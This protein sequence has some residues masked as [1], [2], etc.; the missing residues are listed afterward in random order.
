[1]G[2]PFMHEFKKDLRPLSEEEK[3]LRKRIDNNMENVTPEEYDAFVLGR[4]RSKVAE[5]AK[6]KLESLLEKEKEYNGLELGSGTGIYTK[7][8]NLIPNLK[9]TGIDIRKDMID[10]GAKNGRFLDG[11]V[12]QGDFNRMNFDDNSFELGTGLAFTR[13]RLNKSIFYNELKRVLKNG[14][15]FFVPFTKPKEDTIENEIELM[16]QNGF[17]IIEKSDWYIVAKNS[18][19]IIEKNKES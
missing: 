15:L 1:M 9:I 6:N 3:N 17:E 18:K 16:E 4:E 8:L 5:T 10:F 14:G 13:Q 12:I 2:E 7:E 19:D 11:Q